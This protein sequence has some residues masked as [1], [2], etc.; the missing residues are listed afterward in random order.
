ML[1]SI[2]VR[3]LIVVW[4]LLFA[5]QATSSADDLRLHPFDGTPITIDAGTLFHTLGSDFFTMP[6]GTIY[7]QTGDIPAM[8]LRDAAAQ[9]IPYIRFSDARPALRTWIRA[10]IEREAR[11][12]SSIRMPTRLRPDI[13]CGST[14]GRSTHSPTPCC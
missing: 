13:E 8:W 7:V 11:N 3:W 1:R 9:T 12:I 2:N 10:V 6:D 4:V 5:S 14:N